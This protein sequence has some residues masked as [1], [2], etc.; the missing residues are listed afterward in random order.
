[1]Q[2]AAA[3]LPRVRGQPVC[4]TFFPQVSL[5]RQQPSQQSICGP[6]MGPVVGHLVGPVLDRPNP[7]H[8]R[9]CVVSPSPPP[10]GPWPAGSG[11]WCGA[12]PH[13]LSF[14]LWPPYAPL[15]LRFSFH[16]QITKDAPPFPWG[17][18][19]GGHQPSGH[20]TRARTWGHMA[21]V[22]M[23]R[24]SLSQPRRSGTAPL[25]KLQASASPFSPRP[26]RSGSRPLSA[27]TH[28]IGPGL[29]FRL[30]TFHVAKMDRCQPC[31]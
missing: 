27:P 16:R 17:H 25:G 3:V 15:P 2:L 6:L 30:P 20:T 18:R 26:P 21:S 28:I 22:N 4:S 19:L 24:N 12:P 5:A 13:G 10:A 29:L 7:S 9:C 8:A 1:M 14:R 31:E 11:R 23:P